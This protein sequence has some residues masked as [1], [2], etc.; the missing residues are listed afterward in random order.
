MFVWDKILEVLDRNY[1][2]GKKNLEILVRHLALIWAKNKKPRAGP[3]QNFRIFLSW[4]MQKK[5]EAGWKP[6]FLLK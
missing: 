6:G 5:I 1:G 3:G 2:V 4:N